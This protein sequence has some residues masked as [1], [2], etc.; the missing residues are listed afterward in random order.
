[1]PNKGTLKVAELDL[2]DRPVLIRWA[3]N[4]RAHP[5]IAI[6]PNGLPTESSL[7][8]DAILR[9]QEMYGEA[10]NSQREETVFDVLEELEEETDVE[11][12]EVNDDSNDEESKSEQDSD[13]D[14]STY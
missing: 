11:I 8:E 4:K 14:H 6:I 2:S 3:H 13:D 7:E 5:V 9:D 12:E 1:M 10:V